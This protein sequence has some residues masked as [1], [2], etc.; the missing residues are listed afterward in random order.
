MNKLIYFHGFGSSGEGG[1]V[2]TLRELLPDWTVIAPDIPVDPIEALPFLRELCQKEQPDVI[3]GTSMGGMYAQ[4]MHGFKRICVNPAFDLSTHKDILRE[5]TFEFFNPRKNGKSTFTITPEI[6]EHYAEMEKH[7]FDGYSRKE[8]MDV[9]GLFGSDDTVVDNLALFKNYY[10]EAYTFVGGHRLSREAIQGYLIDLIKVATHGGWYKPYGF[11]TYSVWP[12]LNPQEIRPST[13]DILTTEDLNTMSSIIKKREYMTESEFRKEI[14][15][16]I[17]HK[18]AWVADFY[19][20]STGHRWT[21]FSFREPFSER[22]DEY[23]NDLATIERKRVVRL[24]DVP[25]A[26]FKTIESRTIY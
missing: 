19:R 20:P 12:K 2:R 3:V 15:K 11:R 5:G 6:I 9:Y 21:V 26:Y 24:R 16:G 14:L 18:Y 4:Q 10:E 13:E 25:T 17:E 7:Q 22:G 23:D 8:I 1:T